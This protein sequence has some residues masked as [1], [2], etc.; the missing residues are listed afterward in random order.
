MTHDHTLRDL[1]TCF[2]ID[3]YSRTITKESG[4][5]DDV[6]QYDHNS[7]IFT[8]KVPKLIDGHDMSMCDKIEIHYVNVGTGT[9]VSNRT[10]NADIY[11]VKDLQA[12][13]DDVET[14]MFT[15]KLSQNG[16]QLVGTIRFQIHFICYGDEETEIDEYIW[17]TLVYS[18]INVREGLNCTELILE[19]KPDIIQE[20]EERI[21]D[22]ENRPAVA[23]WDTLLNKP[24][25]KLIKL[26]DI[27]IESL[28]YSVM[29]DTHEMYGQ[30]MRLVKIGE[31]SVT[32]SEFVSAIYSMGVLETDVVV[33]DSMKKIDER[34]AAIVDNVKLIYV[35][36]IDEPNLTV[37][38]ITYPEAGI[39]VLENI[40]V[41]HLGYITFKDTIT[42][43]PEKYLPESYGEMQDDIEQLKEDVKNATPNDYDQFKSEFE[44]HETKFES[45]KSEFESHKSEFNT[46]RAAFVTHKA[47]YDI[48]I[49]TV[50][51]HIHSTR[52]HLPDVQE[53]DAGKFL[54][55]NNVGAWEA[56]TLPNFEESE[57]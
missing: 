53:V 52:K 4:S 51:E 22:L 15:W 50:N 1:D 3:P 57:F 10:S 35:A 2:V 8:F 32:A 5:S 19:Q 45:H 17:N 40:G 26:D 9:S 27:T 44:T 48:D 23:D 54:R 36:A 25:G 31:L 33:T 21:K 7:E 39:Y 37:G 29:T 12:D 28:D 47:E 49:A 43:M 30:Q 24:F 18:A 6:V 42:R 41:G 55:V 38:E 16:T 14:L 46:Y 11:K 20:F 34:C 56:V 13:P